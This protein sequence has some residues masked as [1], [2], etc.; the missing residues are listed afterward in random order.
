MRPLS[1][2]HLTNRLRQLSNGVRHAFATEPATSVL[3][4]D[5]VEFLERIADA[6]VKRGMGVPAAMF[7]ESP[8]R[9]LT[10]P[11]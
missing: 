8:E 7:L 5:D 11:G 6:L 9:M 10:R 2:D 3:R 4:T 1:K